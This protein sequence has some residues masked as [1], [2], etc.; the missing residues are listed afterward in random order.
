MVREFVPAD[1]PVSSVLQNCCTLTSI[2]RVLSLAPGRRQNHSWQQ[3]SPVPC[4]VLSKLL[5]N[6]KQFD[7]IQLPTFWLNNPKQR[8]TLRPHA[9]ALRVADTHTAW[10]SC[11]GSAI[12]HR[13]SRMYQCFG[14][15][16]QSI[17]VTS[18]TMSL[19]QWLEAELKWCKACQSY[20]LLGA[21]AKLRKST[22]SFVL[23]VCPHGATRLP[24]DGF[25]WN[26]TF[27]LFSKVCLENSNII[28]IRKK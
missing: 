28:N 27:E 22:I 9:L 20:S 2:P 21:F 18:W 14:F 23:S 11:T 10:L 3:A 15:L 5:A 19:V 1:E 26:L 8:H 24:L 25:W 13:V 7:A 6:D 4:I 12:F 16:S 17:N